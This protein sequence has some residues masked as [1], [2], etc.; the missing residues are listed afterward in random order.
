MKKILSVILPIAAFALFLYGAVY[1][2]NN[3]DKVTTDPLTQTQTGQT[4]EKEDSVPSDDQ[5]PTEDETEIAVY[6]S[7]DFTVY[8]ANGNAVTL[9]SLVGK[10]VIFNFWASWC[11]PCKAEMPDLEE[12][13]LEYGDRIHFMMINMTDGSQETVS[14]AQAYIDGQ[15]YTF[16]VYF[17]TDMSAAITYSVTSIPATYFVDAEGNLI[18]Y[19]K[20]MLSADNIRQGINMI[21]PNE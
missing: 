15:E 13:Y 10:P 4:E 17:D 18:A 6:P 11:P 1:L 21:L 2:Y 20:G 8:D 16:P 3:L 5:I 9:S 7:L 14:T 12:A 19:G